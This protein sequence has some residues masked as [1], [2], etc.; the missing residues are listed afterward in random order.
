M[1]IAAVV[2]SVVL[3]VMVV[4]YIETASHKG[5]SELMKFIAGR[6]AHSE[7]T[8]RMVS[9]ENAEQLNEL[10]SRPG[11]RLAVQNMQELSLE[12]IYSGFSNTEQD[13]NCMDGFLW[14]P[15]RQ[16][17]IH[18]LEE[19]GFRVPNKHIPFHMMHPEV[20]RNKIIK[21][22]HPAFDIDAERN[23]GRVFTVER[24]QDAA[25]SEGIDSLYF[26]HKEFYILPGFFNESAK[27]S[28]AVIA[29][30][31]ATT[32]VDLSEVESEIRRDVRSGVPSWERFRIQNSYALI[33]LGR[34]KDDRKLH[35][36]D[37]LL[38]SSDY[39]KETI[40]YVTNKRLRNLTYRE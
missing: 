24:L 16:R 35:V 8:R 15:R 5:A 13:K 14:L 33:V 39:L 1:K 30:Y 37:T 21:L 19:E 2:S 34:G 12:N 20:G 4:P 36:I 38:R 28:T 29:D 40:Q 26:P 17:A 23:I 31:V 6:M 7:L 25:L 11:V 27:A 9:G 3:G 18:Y 22:E 10:F 32:P